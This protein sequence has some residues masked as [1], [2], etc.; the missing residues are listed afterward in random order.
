MNSHTTERTD[1][2]V[3]VVKFDKI[4]KGWEQWVMLQSDIHHDNVHCRRDIL[5][6]N[7]K[8]AQEKEAMVIIGGDLFCAMQGKYDP[9]SSMDSIRPEDVSDLYLDKIVES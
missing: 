5:Q 6:D 9:R 3:I 1:T 4:K 8:E 7:L 2:N